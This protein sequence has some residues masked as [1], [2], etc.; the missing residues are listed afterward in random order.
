VIIVLQSCN[1]L[2]SNALLFQPSEYFRLS[3]PPI[4]TKPEARDA[5]KGSVPCPAVDAGRR[6]LEESSYLLNRE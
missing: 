5:V 3:K 2:H 1:V 6:N 4:F